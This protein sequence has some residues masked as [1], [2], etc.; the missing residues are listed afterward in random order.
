MT[1]WRR[2]LGRY[3]ET[4]AE[5]T[6]SK[7]GYVILEKN[8][9]STI[10]EIDLIAIKHDNLVFCEVRSRRL[11]QSQAIGSIGESINGIKQRRLSILAEAYLQHH[12][13]LQHCTCRF[14]VILVAKRNQ[15][16]QIDWIEDAFR[17]GW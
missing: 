12:P 11:I 8:Y 14:D 1:F 16:W 6:L 4:L 5:K 9:S 2:W 17:P 10:G 7:S 13:H 15:D 3:G